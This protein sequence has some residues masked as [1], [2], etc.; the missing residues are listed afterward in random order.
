M[1]PGSMPGIP[2]G[3]SLRPENEQIEAPLLNRVP[4]GDGWFDVGGG[5]LISPAAATVDAS[6]AA[7]PM[8]EARI[9][10]RFVITD[11]LI[12]WGGT[13]DSRAGRS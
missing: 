2:S 4:G 10:E 13:G 9:V 5:P 8:I 12:I 1:P 7:V 3:V 6:M 11:P